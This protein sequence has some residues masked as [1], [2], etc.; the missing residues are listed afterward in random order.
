MNKTATASGLAAV[1][2]LS[3]TSA[4]PADAQDTDIDEV[5][6]QLAE[7]ATA[8]TEAEEDLEEAENNADD[9][10]DEIEQTKSELEGMREELGEFAYEIYMRDDLVD[11][12]SVLT[13]DDSDN[14]LEALAYTDFLGEQRAETVKKNAELVQRLED[15]TDAYEEQ[16]EQAEKALKEAEEAEKDLEDLLEE[17]S[18]QPSNGPSGGGGAGAPNPVTTSGPESCSE[19]D[20]TTS[21]CLTPRTL[22]VLRETQNAGF[23]RYVSCFRNESSGEHGKGRACDFSANSSGF[24]NYD[25]YGDEKTYGDNLAG[26]YVTHADALSVQYVIWYRQFWSPASGWQ[27]YSGTNGNPN[28]DHTNHVHVSVN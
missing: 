20:P 4:L 28:A 15:Q 2:L 27:A 21:G 14:A 25:A 3:L 19:S 24:Q 17:L 11:T 9:L 23:D 18:Y 8:V 7:A 10:E 16:I 22:H 12:A 26:W 5:R 13:S 6:T 1:L